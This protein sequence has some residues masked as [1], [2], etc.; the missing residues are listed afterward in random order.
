VSASLQELA[1]LLGGDVNGNRVSC[2]GPGHSDDDRSLSVTPAKNVD[3]FT[4]HS[5]SPR[6]THDA[7]VAHVKA[8]LDP[9]KRAALAALGAELPGRDDIERAEE[10]RR[11]R[12]ERA[13]ENWD[14]SVS[15]LRTIVEVYLW[16]ERHLNLESDVAGSVIR[17]HPE[18]PWKDKLTG[19]ILRV[20]CMVAA[21]RDVQSNEIV[22]IQRTRL[23]PVGQKI[24]RRMLGPAAGAAIKL[25]GED[26]VTHGL[27]IGEGVETAMTAR[28]LGLRPTW[29][30]GSSEPIKSFPVLAGIESL[31]ILA[32]RCPASAEAIEACGR[33]WC[34]AGREVLVNR[35]IVRKDLNDSWRAPNE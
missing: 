17:Y 5:F 9:E 30:L 12:I 23:S 6:D 19:R 22:A 1:T 28:Q 7:C 33:R 3:G 35:P 27:A 10:K 16:R 26:A 32:E 21:M 2:P 34:A 13:R 11:Q 31:T 29:A 8:R 14:A 4:V 15:P 18:C 25:D 20:P 24:D